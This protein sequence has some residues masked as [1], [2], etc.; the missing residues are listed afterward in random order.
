MNKLNELIKKLCPNGVTFKKL[1]ECCQILDSKRKPI[2]KSAR[3]Q[4]IYPY[5][6]ANG[7]QDYVSDY[8]FNGEFVLVGEDGSV[9]NKNGNPVVTWAKGKIWVNN[10]AHIIG[11]IDGVLLRYLYYYLQTINVTNFIHGNIPKLNQ[12]DFKNLLIAVPPI[13]IQ[14]EIIHILDDFTVLSTE[15]LTNISTELKARQNQYEYYRNELLKDQHYEMMALKNIISKS[16]SGGTPLKSNREYY[17]NGNIPWLRTQD[18]KFNEI[19]SVDRFITEKA[20]EQTSAKWIP[21]NCVIVAISGASAG[22]CA[23]NKFKTTTNQHCLN[24]QIDN[25]KAIYKYVF[26]CVCSKYNELMRMKQGAR[27]DLNSSK[28]LSL[29]IPVPSISIQEKIV[30]I[31]DKYERL[32]NDV[33][34]NLSAEIET[35]QK[36]YKYYRDKLLM[37]NEYF[38]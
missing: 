35:R 1:E 14:Y 24:M 2:T 7:I 11:E 15:L 34:E 36:Q 32:C 37:F 27:G 38:S 17:K 4:G 26:Y 30:N 19:Y 21:E 9:I 13:E 16:C 8:L 22:R 5:Y 25:A 3:V 31:L 28:I 18:V 29:K 23:I 10:H 12:R 20:V 6:G 33:S